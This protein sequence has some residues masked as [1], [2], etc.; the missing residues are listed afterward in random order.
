MGESSSVTSGTILIVD[1][2]DDVRS[3]MRVALE[4]A[5]Y[6]VR[7]A[8]EGGQALALQ[9]EHPADLLITDIFMPGQEGFET[10]TSFT[11]QFP[12]T[13]IIV[14]SAGTLPGL[15]HDFLAT[16]ALLGVGATLR[17]PFDADELLAAVRRVLQP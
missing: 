6:E 17:K 15:K 9:R 2:K 7:T 12:Q 4:Q 3:F 8:S 16:A 14:M 5:G 11:T 10:I 13:R 1:D